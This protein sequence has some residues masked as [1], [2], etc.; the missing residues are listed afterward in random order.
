VGKDIENYIGSVIKKNKLP[1]SVILGMSDGF[2]GN[3]EYNRMRS[4]PNVKGVGNTGEDDYAQW[5]AMGRVGTYPLVGVLCSRQFTRPNMFYLPFDDNVFRDGLESVLAAN[6]VKQVPWE[7]KKPT[8]FWRGGSSG[9]DRPFLRQ[10]VAEKL[11]KKPYANVL[12][13]HGG[14]PENNK[15][16][17]S[18]LFGDFVSPA[19]QVQNKY[20]L[21]IDGA[22][23]A[24]NLM[25]VFGSGSV[26][27]IVSHPDNNYWFKK[28]L[29]PMVNYVPIKYDLSDLEE[30]LEWLVSHDEE[31]RHIANQAYELSK[32]IFN[33]SF[34]Q[35][36]IESEMAQIVS[37]KYNYTGFESVYARKCYTPG[38][39]NQHL[40]VLREYAGKCSRIVECGVLNSVSSYAF[41]TALLGKPDNFYY[42]VDPYRNAGMDE[43]LAACGR[44][45]INAEFYH[46]SDIECP[47]VSADLVFI[48]TWHIYAQLKRELEYWHTYAGKYMILHDTTVDEWEGESVRG[49]FDLEKQS[50]ETGWSVSE[51]GKGLWPAVEEFLEAHREWKLELRLVNNN[52]LTVLRRV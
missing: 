33:P 8:V 24:S 49:R 11:H 30:Q 50:R 35:S 47:R 23:I 27:I 31:S 16:I 44:C 32:V 29:T 21:V 25:W 34:Q 5:E 51:I 17:P 39:I 19:E 1:A 43:F 22:C 38:D 48:D 7:A 40:P 15:Q 26:P 28:F 45:G 20:L 36:Y 52:G 46:G 3:R 41:A 4:T 13:T 37:Y 42:L 12:F 10:R 18:E 2:L 6:G 14:W 9:F